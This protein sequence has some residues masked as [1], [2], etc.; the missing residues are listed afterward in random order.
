MSN[1]ADL[2]KAPSASIE[3]DDDFDAINALYVDRGR[4]DGLP[5]VP[6]TVE[7]VERVLAWCDRAWDEPIAKIAPRYGEATPLRLAANAVIAGCR[8][9]YFPLYMLAIEAMCEE[10]FNL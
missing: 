2:L 6:P 7:R 5:I 3:A 10:A 1:L 4:S 8:P 9:E